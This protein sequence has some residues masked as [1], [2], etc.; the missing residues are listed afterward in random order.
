MLWVPIKRNESLPLNMQVYEQIRQSIAA[1]ELMTGQRLPST[2]T[3]AEEL[4]V[5]RNVVLEA[6]DQ[7]TAEG[8]VNGRPGSGTYVA[9]DVLLKDWA[10]TPMT[11]VTNKMP[12]AGEW[13]SDLA[14]AVSRPEEAVISFR[15]GIPALDL[16]PRKLWGRL[17]RQVIE[18]MNERVL[19]YGDPEGRLELR[20]AIARYLLKTRGI[21]CVPEQ[22]VITSGAS[23]AMFLLAKLLSVSGKTGVV[24]DPMIKDLYS[25]FTSTG[26]VLYPVPVD[27]QGMMTEALAGCANPAFV[28]VTPSHQF[29]LGGI[30]PAQRRNQLIQYARDTD[31]YIIEDDYDSEIRYAG[32]PISTLFGLAPERVIYVGTFSKILA[33]ALRIGYMVLPAELVGRCRRLKWFTDLHT[34]SLDQLVLSRFISE[35]YMEKHIRVVK[36]RYR[37]RRAILLEVLTNHFP[38]RVKILGDSTGLHVVAEFFAIQFTETLLTAIRRYGVQVQSV[39]DYAIHPGRHQQRL[40]LGY[41]HLREAEIVEGIQIIAT[42]LRHSG[43]ML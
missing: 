30:M 35:G 21:R 3:L 6:Y 38:G 34:P 17:F 19:G 8:Y 20:Q 36:K 5:S 2:R 25:V 43:N 28:Y 18:E 22:M 37:R 16:F 23:Q 40:I 15:C 33:P 11:A 26:N 4:S 42:V 41:G 12:F 32:P 31:C 24:E 7:L 13:Q 14:A 29:P 39:E 1:G 10:E 27:E 9:A